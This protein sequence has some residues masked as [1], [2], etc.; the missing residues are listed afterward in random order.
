MVDDAATGIVDDV[1]CLP[2]IHAIDIQVVSQEIVLKLLCFTK[3]ANGDGLHQPELCQRQ[4]ADHGRFQ[5]V[6]RQ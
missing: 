2:V 5:H 1:V 3:L 6:P 4:R